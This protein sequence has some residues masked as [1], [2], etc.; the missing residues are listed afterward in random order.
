MTACDKVSDDK[1]Y[2]HGYQGIHEHVHAHGHAFIME[3]AILSHLLDDYAA[4][5]EG[6]LGADGRATEDKYR[7]Q[8][9]G[10]IRFYADRHHQGRQEC[11]CG[12]C[13]CASP[14]KHHADEEQDDGQQCWPIAATVDNLFCQ[15]HEGPVRYG[16]AIK[17]RDDEQHQK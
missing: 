6:K 4:D 16:K 14:G 2:G 7:S 13:P 11:K 3:T 9:P 15:L 10:N 8:H 5:T 17:C 12:R 1:K